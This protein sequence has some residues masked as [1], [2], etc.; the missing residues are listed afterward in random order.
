MASANKLISL[1]IAS[2]A[3]I[4]ECLK[5]KGRKGSILLDVIPGM[6]VMV[7]HDFQNGEKREKEREHI[8]MRQPVATAASRLTTHFTQEPL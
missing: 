6:T 8:L 4:A 3:E 1:M 2:I 7:G 5:T